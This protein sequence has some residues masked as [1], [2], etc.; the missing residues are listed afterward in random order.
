MQ[1]RRE[2]STSDAGTKKAR[3]TDTTYLMPVFPRAEPSKVLRGLGAGVLEEL[4]L[5]APRWRSPD[6]HV[7]EHHGIA[8]C[9]G[10]H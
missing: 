4:H 5:D 3:N 9:H 7:E 2:A 1:K 6:C 8:P 10:L